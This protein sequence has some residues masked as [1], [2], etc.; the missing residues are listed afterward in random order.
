MAFTNIFSGESYAT[1]LQG[2]AVQVPSE[3]TLM[4]HRAFRTNNATALAVGID[5]V[6]IYIETES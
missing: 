4:A 2:T 5:V 6:S 1:T 3:T